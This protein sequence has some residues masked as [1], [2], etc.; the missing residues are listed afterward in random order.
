VDE[1][2]QKAQI[3][4]GVIG[5]LGNKATQVNT[6]VHE[7]VRGAVEVSQKAQITVGGVGQMQAQH[8]IQEDVVFAI[9]RKI[10]IIR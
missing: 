6:H 4:H 3:T 1:A 9:G 10:K 7:V 2:H 8:S 5:V